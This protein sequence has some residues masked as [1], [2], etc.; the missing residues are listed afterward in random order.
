MYIQEWNDRDFFGVRIWNSNPL[1]TMRNCK[2][3]A[4]D[5]DGKST[6][7]TPSD[8]T[9]KATAPTSQA[10]NDSDEFVVNNHAGGTISGVGE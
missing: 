5:T 4:I 7:P 3:N 1:P 10:P 6:L 2:P 9:Q 8:G